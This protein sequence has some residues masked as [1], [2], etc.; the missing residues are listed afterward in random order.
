MLRRLFLC[1]PLAAISKA[2]NFSFDYSFFDGPARLHTSLAVRGQTGIRIVQVAGAGM[3]I[4]VTTGEL[5]T[6]TVEALWSQ[7]PDKPPA[8]PPLMPGMPN[9]WIQMKREGVEKQIRL[10]ANPTVLEQVKPWI[11]ALHTALQEAGAKPVRTLAIRFHQWTA[12]GAEVELVG[13]GTQEIVIP[14]AAE[15]I[16]IVGAPKE[17]RNLLNTAG[18]APRGLVRLAPGGKRMFAIATKREPGMVY[19]AIYGRQGITQAGGT[20]IF[21]DA[22]STVAPQ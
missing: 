22:S 21:G 9:H 18:R 12:S 17:S 19:Q 6:K 11:A 3:P 1:T 5:S 2:M 20:E 16:Y 10:A 15:A 14:D 13:G 7:F 4:G 8:G